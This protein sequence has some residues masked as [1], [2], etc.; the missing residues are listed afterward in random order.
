MLRQLR[1]V[2]QLTK[3]R[4]YSFNKASSISMPNMLHFYWSEISYPAH[5][6]EPMRHLFSVTTI[7]SA[8]IFF[9][10]LL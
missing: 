1:R 7:H 5:N 9:C 2:H 3:L 4:A 8:G 6:V 10:K